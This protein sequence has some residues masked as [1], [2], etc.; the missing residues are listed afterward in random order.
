MP[1]IPGLIRAAEALGYRKGDDV[2]G[3]RDFGSSLRDLPRLR[4]SCRRRAS[5]WDRSGGNVDQLH[6]EPGATATLAEMRGTGSINHIWITVA[7]K[8]FSIEPVERRVPRS[9]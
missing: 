6:V 9:G 8:H 5:S 4:S 3:Y 7:N 1:G 2:S